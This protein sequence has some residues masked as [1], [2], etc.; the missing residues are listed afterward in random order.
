MKLNKKSII[1]ID[2]DDV[3]CNYT[4]MH[5]ISIKK[6]P[7]IKYPQ[8]EVGF[9]ENLKPIKNS[10]KA[11]NFLFNHSNFDTYILTAPSVRN[12]HCYTEKRVWIENYFG[13]EA[14]RKLIISPNK[15]LLKGDFLI[16]DNSSGKGQE[17]FEGSLLQFGTKTY[18]DWSSII[19]YLSEKFNIQKSLNL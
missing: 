16:D 6:N 9:F 5:S 14:A 13:L 2:M 15:G 8:S 1:Y 18:P 19:N 4:D 10:I 11:V 17:S 7:A 12:S 3:M